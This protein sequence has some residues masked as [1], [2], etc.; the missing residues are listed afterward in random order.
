MSAIATTAV[1]I[2]TLILNNMIDARITEKTGANI[3]T[4]VALN[5]DAVDDLGDD[6]KSLDASVKGLNNDVKETLRIL[7]SS[8]E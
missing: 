1:F 3:I 4:Q 6:I 7:A 5:T 8:H 2:A